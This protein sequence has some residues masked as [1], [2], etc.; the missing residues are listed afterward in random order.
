[1]IFT[2][3]L[4]KISDRTKNKNEVMNYIIG[5]DVGTSSVKGLAIAENRAI[6]TIQKVNYPNSQLP[7][8]EQS[9]QLL[10][11]SCL[12]CI[13]KIIKKLGKEPQ[14]I[15]ICTAMHSLILLNKALEP[16]SNFILWNDKRSKEIAENLK[17]TDLGKQLYFQTGTPIH[18]MS[19]LLKIK[20]LNENQPQLIQQTTYFGDIKSYLLYHLTG[21]FMIDYSTASATGLFDNQLKIWS[22]LALNYCG[23]NAEQLPQP[24]STFFEKKS[25]HSEIS[26]QVKIVSGLSDGCAANLGAANKSDFNHYILSLGTSGAIRKFSKTFETD[27]NQILF[28]YCLDE[29]QYVVGGATNNC[30]NVINDIR[31]AINW[32]EKD[33]QDW[34]VIKS[35]EDSLFFMP[36]KFGERAPLHLF[37]SHSGFINLEDKHTKA[38]QLKAVFEGII[39]NIKN[40]ESL[41][42]N[43]LP[44]TPEAEIHVNGG[45]IR[46]KFVIQLLAN[47]L[48]KSIV[49]Q[50]QISEIAA[51]GTA[52]VTAKAI[53]WADDYFDLKPKVEKTQIIL[54]NEMEV[55]KYKV[56]YQKFQMISE[57]FLS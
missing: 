27:E 5:L 3:V 44:S 16:I 33:Y 1:V 2:V 54:P 28:S 29:N 41:L 6:Q 48:N 35:T 14:A 40:I 49:Y 38:D 25:T 24:V 8:Y 55:E 26:P 37:E 23:I 20:W 15:G 42:E 19:P 31:A 56:S 39:Y 46:S 11:N 4:L 36:W 22:K 10:L 45:M 30:S 50:P 57:Q 18:P 34:K 7:Y 9:P 53:G 17:N 21:E 12:E 51:L 47:I 13:S 43:L 52:Y 32:A